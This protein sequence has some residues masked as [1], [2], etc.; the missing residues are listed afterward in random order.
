MKSILIISFTD[1]SKDPRP[2]KQIELLKDKYKITS[3]GKNPSGYENQFIKYEKESIVS[4]I[5][6]LILLVNKNYHKYYWSE[7][8]KRI[9][10][11]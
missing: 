5:F 1:L 11:K 2:I 6:R 3:V 7:G 8:K 4:E 10:D 9:K